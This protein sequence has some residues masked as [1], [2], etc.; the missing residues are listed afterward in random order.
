MLI[1]F[2]DL[3]LH[4]WIVLLT[5]Y[6]VS[7]LLGLLDFDW[8]KLRELDFLASSVQELYPWFEKR[9]TSLVS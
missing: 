7:L 8:S 4:T 6:Y 9:R 5:D 1:D 3:I 2:A